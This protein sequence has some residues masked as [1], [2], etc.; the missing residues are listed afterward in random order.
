MDGRTASIRRPAGHATE[1]PLPIQWSDVDLDAQT[2][3]WR[4]E[5]E[6]TGYEHRTP[7][8]AAGR[9]PTWGPFW[10]RRG[11]TTPGSG[12]HL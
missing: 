5:Q 1:T 4:G 9:P 6:T 2:I 10:K 3:R 11:G 7:I 12:T 8:T